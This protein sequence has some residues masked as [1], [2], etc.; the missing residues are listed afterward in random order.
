MS[1]SNEQTP[2]DPRRYGTLSVADAADILRGGGLV[3]VPTE[4][5][6][7]LAA[8]SANARAVA[9]IYRT[10]GRP[11]FNP[12]I[13]HVA[14]LDAAKNLAVFDPLALQLAEH[15][16]PGPLTLVLPKAP[17]C[18]A[19]AA[20]T[21]GLETI[22]VRCPAHPL[23]QQLLRESGLYLA[24]PS[25]NRSGGISPTLAEHV[26]ASLG[27]NAPQILDGG[28]CSAGLESTIVAVAGGKAQILR[29]GP[30]TLAMVQSV[31]GDAVTQHGK[32][33]D[34]IQSPGQLASHY[35][36]VKPLR[37]HVERPES[38][39]YYLGLG[40]VQCHDNLSSSGDLAEAASQLF[41]AL[42]RADA[43][44]CVSIAIAPI[45]DTGMGEAI[46]DRLRRAAHRDA[47]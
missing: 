38:G 39:E 3:A 7:G 33:A 24:A 1:G 37:L 21:A 9:D 29:P 25:A 41:A 4:T 42:H 17:L 31:V 20:V 43:S 12:L 30:V 18:P 6:Y 19:V 46:N 26:R 8:D 22:A 2:G 40:S 27:S 23:M 32:Q 35:A 36:P 13:V 14:D 10:K 16:W 44:D 47:G 34:T 45:P 5:V 15:F 11:D 28:P